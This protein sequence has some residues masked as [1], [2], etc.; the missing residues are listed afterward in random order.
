MKHIGHPVLG[1]VTYGDADGLKRQALH[2]SHI[3]FTHPSTG[4]HV[5]F[6]SPLPDDIMDILR[7][8]EDSSG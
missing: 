7:K 2:A 4:K 6:D 1:D 8:A 5:E 3:G